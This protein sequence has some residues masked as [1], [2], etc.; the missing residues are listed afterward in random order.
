M[1]L[2][3]LSASFLVEGSDLVCDRYRLKIYY[4][5]S[6]AECWC[7]CVCGYRGDYVSRC[8]SDEHCGD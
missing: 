7:G 3:H 5:D 4:G 8:Y 2:T 1:Y 6:A